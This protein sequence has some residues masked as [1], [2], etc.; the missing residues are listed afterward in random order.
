MHR[1]LEIAEIFD[2]VVSYLD[3][4]S[5]LTSLARVSRSFNEP[6]INAL[7]A[8]LDNWFEFLMFLPR[9]LWSFGRTVTGSWLPT[10]ILFFNR[11]LTEDEW[12]LF[13][14]RAAKVR[15]IGTPVVDEG[16][17]K[18]GAW[19]TFT[20]DPPPNIIDGQRLVVADVSVTDSL[21][22]CPRSLLFPNLRALT[23]GDGCPVEMLRRFLPSGLRRLNV[24]NQTIQDFSSLPF[25][26][27]VLCPSMD[28]FICRDVYTLG[29]DSLR[30]I[31]DWQHL[32]TLQGPVYFNQ[33][34][35]SYLASQSNLSSLEIQTFDL[36]DWRI[37]RNRG[38]LRTVDN[39]SLT[40]GRFQDTAAA[41]EILFGTEIVH[42]SAAK[43]IVRRL[44]INVQPASPEYVASKPPQSSLK[45]L[46]N[47]LRKLLSNEDLKEL[48][49]THA[50]FSY[51]FG[52]ARIPPGAS[53]FYDAL[54][55]LTAF[56]NV[57]VVTLSAALD[58]SHRFS[59]SQL[60]SLVRHW[61]SLEVLSVPSLLNSISLQELRELCRVC[62]RLR[63]VDVRV[64][65]DK[66]LVDCILA[67]SEDLSHCMN[68]ITCLTLGHTSE[69]KDDI[70]PTAL[71]ISRLMPRLMRVSV[72]GEDL[73][74][75]LFWTSVMKEAEKM[76]STPK[77]WA[78]R[79]IVHRD[80]S[81]TLYEITDS[82]WGQLM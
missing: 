60:L 53:S 72:F 25:S 18:L 44:T 32:R 8:D 81:P 21:M 28:S 45:G 9:D 12:L 67:D 46:T 76:S 49:L 75:M 66:N 37:M 50:S 34:L 54:L 17:R 20:Y 40:S 7:Y 48:H 29:P 4:K 35:W 77:R 59:Y 15:T 42:A 65:M 61:K 82:S 57:S 16:Y 41:L 19:N 63:E 10:Q 14:A 1:C 22:K 39:L 64:I 24:S 13:M 26:I 43:P 55:P 3:Q 58:N 27:A 31:C 11:D 36:P 70:R 80:M 68:N 74:S 2:L 38:R 73:S 62:P 33:K 78:V 5:S 52:I 71:A 23:L 47:A 30:F 56:S 51:H 6:A 69:E 79:G